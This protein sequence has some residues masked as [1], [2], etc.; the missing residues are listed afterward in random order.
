[1][2]AGRRVPNLGKSPQLYRLL[3]MDRRHG[4]WLN[5]QHQIVEV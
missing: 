2:D 5:G 3:V 4:A 1:V